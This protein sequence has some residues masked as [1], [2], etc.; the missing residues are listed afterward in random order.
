MIMARERHRRVISSNNEIRLSL[1]SC[2]ALV[3]SELPGKIM[4]DLD[5]GEYGT[6]VTCVPR[7]KIL[8]NWDCQ[9]LG[10]MALCA[11]KSDSQ[12]E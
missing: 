11:K 6:E 2:A 4:A 10:L 7:L 12:I 5:L 8:W 1:K 3:A 9:S